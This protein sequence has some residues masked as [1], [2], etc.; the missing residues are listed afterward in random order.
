MSQI[1]APALA[2]QPVLAQLFERY[3]QR[4]T[5]QQDAL[6]AAVGS[7]LAARTVALSAYAIEHLSELSE[8]K[9]NRWLG[10]IQGVLIAGG[11][12][13]IDEERNHTR[14]LFHALKGISQTHQ[15]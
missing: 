7:E 15:A 11:L 10:F 4:A 2:W 3:R 6:A 13:D 5:D 14:P 12:A 1:S 8:D 9:A